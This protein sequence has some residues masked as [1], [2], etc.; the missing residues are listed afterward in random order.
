MISSPGDATETSVDL[1][2]RVLRADRRLLDGDDRGLDLRSGLWLLLLTGTSIGLCLGT[3][4]PTRPMQIIH[5]SLKVPLLLLGTA[6]LTLPFLI[7]LLAISGRLDQ[8]TRTVRAILVAE[9]GFATCIGSLGP[10]VVFEAWS[11]VDY[12]TIRLLWIAVFCVGL[13]AAGVLFR[14][15]LRDSI[16]GLSRILV[17]WIGVH[18]LAGV[19]LA[20]TL[21]PFIG[22]PGSPTEFIRTEG[23]ENAFLQIGGMILEAI[24]R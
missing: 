1:L 16:P 18:A 9:I 8:V 4:D 15:L 22:R 13:V 24:I 19:Q 2:R 14:R 5:S 12:D 3:C 10:I 11:G 23:L 6:G 20:W 21:R 7:A 17:V